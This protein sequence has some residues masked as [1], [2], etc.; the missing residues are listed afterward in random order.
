MIFKSRFQHWECGSIGERIKV[1]IGLQ[2]GFHIAVK[3]DLVQK[4]VN[5]NT[6]L[7]LA[8]RY[9]CAFVELWHLMPPAE[10][11]A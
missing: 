1:R 10:E 4:S 3:N 7:V 2:A 11:V 9:L 5:L 6:R 8:N